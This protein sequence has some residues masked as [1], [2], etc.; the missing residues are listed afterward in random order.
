MIDRLNPRLCFDALY[1]QAEMRLR[2]VAELRRAMSSAWRA[3]LTPESSKRRMERARQ[4]A[5]REDARRRV[6]PWE[7]VQRWVSSDIAQK[8]GVDWSMVPT[9]NTGSRLGGGVDRCGDEVVSATADQ[10][11]G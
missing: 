7:E 5:L 2:D 8:V 6:L 4:I 9:I 1:Q 11:P 3:S 10:L